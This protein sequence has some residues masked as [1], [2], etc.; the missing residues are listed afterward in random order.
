MS[1]SGSSATDSQQL[2]PRAGVGGK[3]ERR[4]NELSSE[5]WSI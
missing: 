1:T 5:L 2:P 4:Q 3:I